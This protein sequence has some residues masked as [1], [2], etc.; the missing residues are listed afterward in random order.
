MTFIILTAVFVISY[1]LGSIPFGYIVVKLFTGK[2]IM[3]HGTGNV[4]TMNTHRTTNNKF[5]TL[6]VLSGDL[7]KGFLCY[8]ITIRCYDLDVTMNTNWLIGKFGLSLAIAGFALILGHNYSIFLKFKGG[9]GLAAGA[10]FIF[11][12]S[13]L[14]VLVWIVSF[15]IVVAIS[16]YMVLGQM[17]ASFI[18]PIAAYFIDYNF[19]IITVPLCIL[20]LIKHAP[21]MKDVFD[22][23]E[24]KMYYKIK[25]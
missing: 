14:L 16:R 13:P 8:I 20:V 12:F 23:S 2:N 11:G 15:L 7:L 5:L 22:G 9:K 6:L 19:F 10:G 17:I 18:V 3:E 24:P 4:G 21:R 1:L 25:N